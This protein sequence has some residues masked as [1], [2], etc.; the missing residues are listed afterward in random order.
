MRDKGQYS[1]ILGITNPQ[2]V[3]V[4]MALGACEVKV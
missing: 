3:D 1:Q 2:V 4:E